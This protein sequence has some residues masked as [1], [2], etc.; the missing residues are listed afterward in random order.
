M[1]MYLFAIS[2]FVLGVF[3]GLRL[4]QLNKDIKYIRVIVDELEDTISDRTWVVYENDE[5][6]H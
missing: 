2:Y 6:V 5:Y 3:I 4:T 1:F